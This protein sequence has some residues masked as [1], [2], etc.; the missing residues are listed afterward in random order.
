MS[1]ERHKLRRKVEQLKA[2]QGRHSSF[3]TIY[4]PPAKNLTDII[5][6]VR[7]ELA[8]ADNIKSKANRKNV[9]DNLTAILSELTKIGQIPENGI[10]FFY[11]VE[12]LGGTE[13]EIRELVVPPTPI[14]QFFYLC[15]REFVTEEL[16]N[17]TKPKSLVVIVLIEGGKV[18]VGYL[19]G[20][21]ME[22]IRDEDF[23][24][25]GKTRAGG[26][27]AKRY[28]RLREEKMMEFFKF[29]G[30]MLN[31][32]LID[33][34][35]NVDAIV[36]GGNTIRCQ[37]FLEKGDLDYRLREK[38]AETIIPV[39]VIDETGLYQAMKE[40]S[41]ILR[42]TEIYAERQE[43]DKF[44]EDLMKGLNTVTYG[45]NEVMEALRAGRVDTIMV[46]EDL[47]D[48]MDDLYD[49]I[50]TYGSKLMVFSNQTES[51]AQ[52]KGFG[53]MAARLRW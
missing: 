49:E 39:S 18:T 14:S 45:K 40:A 52:L 32:L 8:G 50:T 22:L 1:A 48:Q 4:V 6:F 46:L 27:S 10:A 15:G 12:E 26:Q 33:N 43:W 20:K 35:E 19:R 7:T 41:R 17:M 36:L 23:Y 16:E 21:H 24:I 30:R 25:I 47:S 37:E 28:M 31:N 38:V 5:S 2:Y 53:G 3:T 51:G 11:G 13:K 34:L 9:T 29:V 44:M 42:E